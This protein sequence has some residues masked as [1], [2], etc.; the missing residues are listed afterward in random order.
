MFVVV[1]WNLMRAQEEWC[2]QLDELDDLNSQYSPEEVRSFMENRY[3][4]NWLE[5]IPFNQYVNL[6][7]DIGET[8]REPT[9]G[10]P[11]KLVSKNI[12]QLNGERRAWNVDGSMAFFR[13]HT[14]KITIFDGNTGDALRE[15]TFSTAEFPA[16]SNAISGMRWHPTDPNVI[17]YARRNELRGLNVQTGA[18][19]VI[20][21]F[22][23]GD[24][25]DGGYRI[26]GGDGNDISVPSGRFLIS[27]GKLSNVFVYDFGRN[28]V[29]RSKRNGLAG[30][31]THGEEYVNIQRGRPEPAFNLPADCDYAMV[32]ASGQYIVAL[33]DGVGTSL[34]D[35]NG[36]YLGM[37]Y[38]TTPHVDVTYYNHNG[39]LL[40]GVII[41][42]TGANAERYGMKPGDLAIVC[43][44]VKT[45]PATGGRKVE[46]QVFKLL[47]WQNQYGP[48]GG[49]Q[50]SAVSVNGTSMLVA[51]NP[52]AAVGATTWGIYFDEIVELSL[53]SRDPAPRRLAHHMVTITSP[54][55]KQ[56]EA[57]LSNDGKK[58]FF[59]SHIGGA[60]PNGGEYL[61]FMDFGARTCPDARAAYLENGELPDP[62]PD[63]D[64][65]PNPGNGSTECTLPAG[66][67]AQDVGTVGLPGAACSDSNGVITM[68]ATGWDIWRANDAFHYMYQT[69][70]GDGEITVRVNS[71]D[72]THEYAKAGVMIRENLTD[73]ASN[74]LMYLSPVGRWTFQRRTAKGENTYSTKSDAGAISFPHWVRLVRTGVEISAYHSRDGINWMLVDSDYVPMD[75][76]VYVGLAV[77]SHDDTR[78]ATAV[79]ENLSTS[80][81]AFTFPVELVSFDAMPEPLQT[82]V[83]LRWATASEMNNSHFTVERSI[84]GLLYEPVQEVLSQ[85][86]SNETRHYEA[87]DLRPETGKTFYRLKQTDFD[88]STTISDRVEV[89]YDE[90]ANGFVRAFPVPAQRGTDLTLTFDLPVSTSAHVQLMAADGRVMWQQ[91]SLVL[92][93]GENE[94]RLATH[95][96]KPGVYMVM[97]KGNEG[98]EAPLSSQLIITP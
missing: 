47:D 76:E 80:N 16:G 40:E 20:A 70:S 17:V 78:P 84:D 5:R 88:G 23:H 58:M 72:N 38:E 19:Y 49:G 89:W 37:L 98:L 94:L 53:D 11:I 31:Y 22:N 36:E 82:R 34:L 65:D 28:A 79:F 97:V 93:A 14:W 86:N 51:L 9:F 21:A 81:S 54:T 63:P 83:A 27:H 10:F 18:D 46:R 73:G 75:N 95:M 43:W 69:L 41:K 91:P 39:Q 68:T 87:Y 4:T 66:W 12:N 62:D 1:S 57:W 26:A 64:P 2:A 32:S 59:K 44:E 30:S 55:I 13:T 92:H 7:P 3:G 52:S 35:L 74:A 67:A 85:G 56:T 61:F 24:I 6:I 90:R 77:T 96:L 45:D 25:G 71:L 15:M 8:F 33:L 50:F 42:Q 48:P 60:L 29:V